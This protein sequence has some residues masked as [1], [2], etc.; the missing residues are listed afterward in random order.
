MSEHRTVSIA[1]QIFAQLERDILSGKYAR[2]EIL[3]EMRL[4]SELGVSRTPIRE[5]L[6][7]LEQEMLLEET[8]KGSCVVGITRRDI[9]D[10]YDIRLGIE[11]RCAALA[12]KNISDEQLERMREITELQKFYLQNSDEEQD[13]SAK[14]KNLDSEFHQLLY[15]S[16]GS[17][18]YEATLAPMH[19]KMTKYRMVSI[20]RTG[21]AELSVKEHK[22]IY[23]ALKAH[24]EALAAERTVI[25]VQN[26]RD[27][28]LE[29][30]ED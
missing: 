24:D 29:Q 3:T 5:A 13:N 7:L 9:M 20:R 19:K 30:K 27:S 22:A 15:R 1:D 28:I 11:G 4:S 23:D 8:S 14:I 12:A 16:S 18:V 25:H 17:R 21:R 26:A 10:M 2:G 6:K